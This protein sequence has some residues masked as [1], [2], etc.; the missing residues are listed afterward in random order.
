[1]LGPDPL[2]PAGTSIGHAISFLLQDVGGAIRKLFRRWENHPEAVTNVEIAI[3]KLRSTIT[4][5]AQA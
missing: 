5:P 4:T 3:G 1:M 2:H